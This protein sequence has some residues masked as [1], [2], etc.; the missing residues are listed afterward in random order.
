[1]TSKDDTPGGA[2]G[3]EVWPQGV[4]GDKDYPANQDQ[5]WRHYGW[6]YVAHGSPLRAA[7]PPAPCS[8]GDDITGSP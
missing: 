6:I 5:I 3:S 7:S 4:F 8:F 1:L 2:D